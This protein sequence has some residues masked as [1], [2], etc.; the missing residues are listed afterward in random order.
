L[1]DGSSVTF[2]KAKMIVFTPMPSR[3]FERTM[4][5]ID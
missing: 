5:S 2:R 3:D 4:R 1:P